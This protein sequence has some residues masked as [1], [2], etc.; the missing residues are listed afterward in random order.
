MSNE[1]RADVAAKAIALL[2]EHFDAG[3]ILLTF[4]EDGY[5]RRCVMGFGN[6]YARIGM[7]REFI[8]D[9]RAHEQD[10]R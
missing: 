5:T 1:Q 9:D 6:F 3:Q 10:A 4:Q 8:E 2:S 7:A